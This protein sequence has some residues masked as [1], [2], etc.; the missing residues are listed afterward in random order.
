MLKQFL[1]HYLPLELNRYVLV[2]KNY[3]LSID[4]HQS[5]EST[6]EKLLTVNK[7]SSVN[8][9]KTIYRLLGSNLGQIV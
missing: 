6:V 8:S 3:W 5:I 7:L 9:T 1:F 4:Y 2:Y